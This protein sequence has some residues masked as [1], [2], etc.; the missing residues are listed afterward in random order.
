MLI[1][2]A[3]TAFETNGYV[4]VTVDEIAQRAGASRGT[5]YLYF[6]SKSGI[7]QAIL[8]ELR[9]AVDAAGLFNDLTAMKKPTVDGI[10]TWFEKYVDFY[11]Q[12]HR[13]WHA[14]R[15]AQVVEPD[16]SLIV[17]ASIDLYAEAWKSDGA[18]K[19]SSHTDARLTATMM[20][21]FVDQF[22]YL[23][24]MQGHHIDRTKA[25][26]ALAEALH[27]TLSG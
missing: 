26:R 18:V 22:M 21:T 17:T 9:L 6:Q 25:T 11:L 1:E 3:R 12:H 16:F 15:Q 27:S 13:L 10:Q 23:W 5:F 8:A 24:L 19:S 4:D 2:A 14:I 7:L 20:Y